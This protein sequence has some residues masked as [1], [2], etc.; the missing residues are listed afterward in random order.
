VNE[1]GYAGGPLLPLTTGAVMLDEVFVVF[2]GK[3]SEEGP[4][5]RERSSWRLIA[6]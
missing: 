6:S 1:P 2:M 3:G 4:T 5:R